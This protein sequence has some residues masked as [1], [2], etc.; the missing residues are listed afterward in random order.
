MSKTLRIIQNTFVQ[1]VS[2]LITWGLSWVLLI[3]LPRKL[4]DADFGKLFFAMSY[5]TIFSVFINLGVN[6]WLT[7]EVAALRSETADLANAGR[8]RLRALLG[9]VLAMKI[10]LALGIYA[11]QSALIFLLPYDAATRTAVLIVGAATCLGALTLTL[12]GAFQGLE[13]MTIPNVGLVVEKVVVTVGCV[14]LLE[15]GF[16][17][18]PVCWVHL[19]ASAFDLLIV[20]VL[21]RRRIPFEWNFDAAQ[22]RRIFLG[23]LPFLVW[24]VFGEIYVRIDVVMLSMMTSAAVVGWY[25][26]AF[27]LYGSILFLPNLVCTTVFPALSRMGAAGQDDQVFGRAVSRIFRLMLFAAAPVAIGT[28]VV[29]EPIVHYLYGGKFGP[30]GPDLQ[31]FGIC[32]LLVSVDVVLG[33]VLIARGREKAWAC[34]AVAGAVFNPLMNLWM[35]PLAQRLYGNGGIGAAIATALTEALMMCGALWLIPRGLLERSLL[36]ATLRAVGAAVA[37]GLV[38]HFLPVHNPLLLIAVGAPVYGALALALG[39]LPRED[40]L[41][42]WHAIKRR[43]EG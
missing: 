41:H 42:V 39:V 19:A 35:I 33:S 38:L 16:G 5:G 21:L 23:G 28:V 36:A 34:M 18:I 20:Y 13:M 15:R 2:Q 37:M 26:A 8:Q 22:M 3:V 10:A 9:N 6:L 43:R 30:V 24:V 14:A 27:R 12:S 40:W 11:L 17:L 1:G 4:G 32:M 29:A 31:I 7:R 25:G